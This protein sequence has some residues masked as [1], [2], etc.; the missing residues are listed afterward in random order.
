MALGLFFV[1]AVSAGLGN[2]PALRTTICPFGPC[3]RG[4]LFVDIDSAGF[5]NRPACG[6][7]F[8]KVV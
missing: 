1:K 3:A 5:G 6:P 4:P 2:G 7:L 8:V